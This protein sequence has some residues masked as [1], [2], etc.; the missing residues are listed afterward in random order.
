MSDL[1]ATLVEF[2][3]LSPSGLTLSKI[4]ELLSPSDKL[5]VFH[6]IDGLVACGAGRLELAPDLLSVRVLL[7][8]RQPGETLQ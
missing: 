1:Q 2:L 5:D 7:I 8:P 4:V 3:S 6:A